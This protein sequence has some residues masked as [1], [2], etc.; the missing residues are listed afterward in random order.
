MICASDED[1][2]EK[3]VIPF[4]PGAF[5]MSRR[6]DRQVS[7]L[8]LQAIVDGEFD[9]DTRRTVMRAVMESPAL[10]ERLEYLIRQKQNLQ[11]YWRLYQRH[12][13]H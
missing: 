5:F 6:E 9:D 12:T 8:D 3:P 10:L 11:D 2:K 1:E 4:F 7:D 13:E